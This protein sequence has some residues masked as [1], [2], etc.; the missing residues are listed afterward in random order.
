[1]PN[2]YFKFKQFTINQEKCAMKVCTD[3]CLFGAWAAS[4]LSACQPN[5]SNVLDIGTGTGLLS[6]MI[7][8]KLPFATIDAVEINRL[9]AEQAAENFTASD[10]QSNFTVFHQPLQNFT[11]AKRY[12]F[13]ISNPPFYENDLLATNAARN[14][15]LHSADLTIFSLIKAIKNHLQ[16]S[17]SFALLLPYHRTKECECL[18]NKSGFFLQKKMLVR[19]TEQ[20]SFFRS[21]TLFSTEKHT[22]EMAEMAIKNAT[23]KY[24]E[25][26]TALLQDY[27]LHL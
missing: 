27:Y 1:M 8:Q 6:L 17:G 2:S 24:T 23:G 18:A 21:L 26:F 12:D 22:V 15:A 10:W 25:A 16:N 13:I 20:H 3:A 4:Y 9:A 5:T 19:Q 7:A 11:S 14:S